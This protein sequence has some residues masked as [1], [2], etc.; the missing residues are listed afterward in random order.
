MEP[1]T[2]PAAHTPTVALLRR[3]LRWM[4]VSAVALPA[5]VLGL[6]GWLAWQATE[7]DAEWE[8][9]RAADAAAEYAVRTLLGYGLVAGRIDALLHGLPDAE[10]RARE[11]ELH[12]AL[13]EVVADLPQSGRAFALDRDGV[14]LVAAGLYPV[15]RAPLGA[16]RDF[17]EALI[18]PVAPPL[19]V[20]RVHTD[21]VDGRAFFAVSRRRTGP[22]HGPQPHGFDGVVHVS[23]DP[24]AIGQG[25][26][27][28]AGSEGD[29]IILVR[30]DG[31][32]LAGSG[33]PA[34]PVPLPAGDGAEGPGGRVGARTLY[35]AADVAGDPCLVAVS[36]LATLPLHVVAVRPR[37]VI[38]ARWWDTVLPQIAIAGPA[39]LALI[40]LGLTVIRAQHAVLRANGALE[41]RV[42]E[43]TAALRNMTEALDLTPCMVT[44][45]DGHILHWSVGCQKLYGFTA[46][47]ALGRHAGTLLSTR[48]PAEGRDGV[49]ATLWRSGQWQGELLQRRKDGRDIITGNHWTLRCAP[50]TGI[51]TA[52][53]SVRTDLTALRRA[54]G[55]LSASEARLRRAQEAGGVAPF[56]ARAGAL[57]VAD[58]ALLRLHGLPGGRRRA[59]RRVSLRR[60]LRTVHPGDRALMMAEQARLARQ[61]GS[62]NREYRVVLP[63]GRVRWLQA[64]GEATAAAG[65]SPVPVHVA[66]VILDVTTRRA[67][68]AALAEG[69]ERLQ[70][71]QAAGGFGLYDYD[72][73]SGTVTWDAR[74]R[75][76]WALPADLPMTNRLFLLGLH[77]EDRARRREAMRRAIRSGG[78]QVYEGEYR[79]IGLLDGVERWVATTG[80][81][82]FEGGRPARLIG[83]ATDITERKRAEA[84]NELLMRE[85]DHRAKNALAVVQAVLRL[86]RAE[87][88]AELVRIVEGRVAALARAQ[89][90]LARRRWEGAELRALLEGELAP[91]LSQGRAGGPRVELSGPAFTVAAQAAQPF[92]MAIHELA[93][94]A[95]KYGALSQAGGLV[96]A[97][98]WVEPGG[99]RLHLHWSESGGP[100]LAG[101]PARRGFG[102][103]VIEQTV[104]AQ[105]GGRLVQRWL[106]GGLVCEIAVPISARGAEELPQLDS[107]AA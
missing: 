38:L 32:V 43:R 93:T 10:I 84:R 29:R 39:T 1:Q 44:D 63:D 52:I 26:R 65:G 7:R 6:S 86:S 18:P 9:V 56:E 105:L 76:L 78:A 49:I 100:P 45:P 12:Q 19:Y 98:W 22:G 83:F 61:G 97:S 30:A 75:A 69:M 34:G 57:V 37:A 11:A 27:R 36:P 48:F 102:S 92:S 35:R 58:D 51:P 59:V 107:D 53:V 85:V 40:G 71:A 20:S 103:R 80:R 68:E 55:A 54:E 101:S 67:A 81:V 5:I 31:Q 3:Y 21:R 70:L 23:I 15:P 24:E 2:M 60:L 106:P 74:M 62:F 99:A 72:F 28:L 47:E 89:T 73:V 96:R 8:L 90:M 87:T 17:F 94:N 41:E 25:L 95:V 88:P 91:F 50:T 42:A 46:R 13:N 82:R 64:R 16:G 77:P 14:P 4:L 79:V 66:G 33:R 104:Q